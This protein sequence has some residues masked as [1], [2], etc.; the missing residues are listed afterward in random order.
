MWV[1]SESQPSSALPR[2]GPGES[3]LFR[4]GVIPAP[5]EGYCERM[6]GESPASALEWTAPKVIPG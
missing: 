5:L 6:E 3:R 4:P 2:R 1:E